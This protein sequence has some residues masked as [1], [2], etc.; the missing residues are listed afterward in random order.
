MSS[1]RLA[2]PSPAHHQS[3]RLSG[4]LSGDI[5]AELGEETQ[6]DVAHEVILALEWKNNGDLGCAYYVTADETLYVQKDIPM[7]GIEMVETVL[8]HA[9]PSTV[10]IPNRSSNKLADFLQSHAQNTVAEQAG[11][12]PPPQTDAVV[13]RRRRYWQQFARSLH[14]ALCIQFQFPV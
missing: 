12:R 4:E 6:L 11:K 5:A 1:Q 9:Q 8:L 7:A 10:I 14:L 13:D 3:R 2:A